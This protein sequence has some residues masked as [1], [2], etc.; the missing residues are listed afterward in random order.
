LKSGIGAAILDT[1]IDGILFPDIV[2]VHHIG[3]IALEAKA[4]S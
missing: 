2:G 1:S 3:P 4:A